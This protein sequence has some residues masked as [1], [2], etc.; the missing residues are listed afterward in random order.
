MEPLTAK[1][2]ATLAFT[3][4]IEKN[5]EIITQA[6][7]RKINQLQ[8]KI[9]Q[10]LLRNKNLEIVLT[11]AEIVEEAD[12]ETVV[13]EVQVAMDEDEQFSQEIQKIAGEIQ[14]EINI[15]NIIDLS[16]KLNPQKLAFLSKHHLYQIIM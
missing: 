13:T 7:L 2:I 11:E 1:V 16:A 12:L 5:T 8:S 4:S 3:F 14:Q 10:K 6:T 9:E 15:G